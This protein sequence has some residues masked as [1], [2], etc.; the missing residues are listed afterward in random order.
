MPT[1]VHPRTG[2]RE[3]SQVPEV[4][5]LLPVVNVLGVRVSTLD[6]ETTARSIIQWAAEPLVD[7]FDTFH[8]M[9]TTRLSGRS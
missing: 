5:D 2:V 9:I 7:G 4:G 8:R 6:L 3:Q 1:T